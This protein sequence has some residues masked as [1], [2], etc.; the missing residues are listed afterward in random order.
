MN[1]KELKPITLNPLFEAGLSRSRLC[2][3][4]GPKHLITLQLCNNDTIL[5]TYA[6]HIAI[7]RKRRK[8]NHFG[9]PQNFGVCFAV[10]VAIMGKT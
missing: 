5:L 4:C 1:V 10:A 2:L 8:E 7:S 9:L 3:C 6:L